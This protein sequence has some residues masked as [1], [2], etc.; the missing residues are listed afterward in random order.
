MNHHVWY[1]P[2]WG[3]LPARQALYQ[4]TNPCPQLFFAFWPD[5]ALTNCFISTWSMSSSETK[6]FL[7]R[8]SIH[9]QIN[10]YTNQSQEHLH[11][12]HIMRV[13]GTTL[14]HSSLP[15]C[16]IEHVLFISGRFSLWGIR[17]KQHHQKK[18]VY[19]GNRRQWNCISRKSKDHTDV[20][21]VFRYFRDCQVDRRKVTLTFPVGWEVKLSVADYQT[22]GKSFSGMYF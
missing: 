7:I 21:T 8:W 15:P 14:I 18:R 11:L 16:C 19:L 1:M 3:R 12:T 17:T 9:H 4:S 5:F 20:T 6:C 10:V 2:R 22:P 13:G